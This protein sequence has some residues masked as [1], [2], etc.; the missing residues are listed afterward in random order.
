M[1]GDPNQPSKDEAAQYL[2]D[3]AGSAADLAEQAGL[4]DTARLLALAAEQAQRE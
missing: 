1:N 2:T 4:D 3:L